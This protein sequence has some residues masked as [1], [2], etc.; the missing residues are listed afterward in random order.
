MLPPRQARAA[1]RRP[2]VLLKGCYALG[3]FSGTGGVSARL[4]A[5]GYA[6]REIE[7]TKGFN[8]LGKRL[9]PEVHHLGTSALKRLLHIVQLVVRVHH[10]LLSLGHLVHITSGNTWYLS[11]VVS[12]SPQKKSAWVKKK[13]SP[14]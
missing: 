4:R 2:P 11:I 5:D 10:M 14:V 13:S 6:S 9:L 1:P 7:L 8:I 3:M 12:L